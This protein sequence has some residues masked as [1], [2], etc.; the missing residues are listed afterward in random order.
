[1]FEAHVL[2]LLRRYLGEYVHGLSAEALRISVWK[3]DVVLKDLKLKAEAL[4][5]LRLPVMVKAGFVGTITLKVPWKSLGKEPVIV[6]IDRVF[7]LAHPAP[8]GRTLEKEDHEKLFEAKLRQ[9]E[10]AESA[11][12]EAISRSKIGS[13]TSGSSWLTSLIATIIG[14]LKISVSNIHIRYEDTVNNPGHPF[15]CGVTLSKL[16][17]VTTDEQGNETFDTSGALDKLRKSLQLER[18]AMYHDSDSDPWK[19]SKKW[20]DLIPQEWIEIFEDGIK[21]PVKD[22]TV[23]SVWARDRKYVVSPINGVLKYHRLGD[24]E[25]DD[26]N[27]PFEKASVAINDVTLTITEPQYHDWIRLMEVISRYKMY[28]EV[29][30]LRPMVPVSNNARLWWRFGAQAGLQLKKMCYRFSWDQI[31]SLCHL[32]RR[33][34]QLYVCLLQ[35]SSYDSSEIRDIEKNLDE[36]VILLWRFLAHAKVESVKSKEAAE[37]RMQRKNSWFSFTWRTPDEDAPI[38]SNSEGSDQEEEKFTKEEWEAINKLLSFQPD[39]D[40]TLHPGK[41]VQ[42]LIRYLIEVS[43]SKA[44]TRIISSDQKEIVCGSF[45]NLQVSTKFKHSTTSCDLTLKF[46][47]LSSPEGSLA[48]SVCSEQKVNALAAHLVHSPA[49]ENVDWKL[50]ATI[51]PCHVTIFVESYYRFLEFVKRSNAVS[52]TV[53]LETATALQHKFEKVTRKAQE[54]IQMVL[55]EHSRFAL[56]IDLDAPKVRIPIREPTSSKCDCHLLLDFGHFTLHTKDSDQSD[57]SNSL[58]SRFYISG[59]DIAALFTNCGS[60][61]EACALTSQP[62]LSPSI[63][64]IGN[65]YALVDPCGMAVVVDKIKVMHPMHPSMRV[66]VQVPGLSIHFSPSRLHRIMELLNILHLALSNAEQDAGEVVESQSTPWNPADIATT[67]RVLVWKGIGYSIA[68]WQPCFL[69]LS[70]LNLYV[71]ESESSH[72]YQRCSSMSGKQVFEVPVANVGGSPLCIAVCARGMDYQKALESFS[73]LIVELGDEEEKATWLR[74]LTHATYRAS[75][76]P[77]VNVLGESNEITPGLTEHQM[78]SAKTAD[79]IISGTLLETRLLLYGEVEDEMHDQN[80]EACILEV[81]ACGGK[82]HVSRWGGDLTAKMKLHSLK[83]KDELQRYFSTGHRYLACS[84]LSD[85]HLNTSESHAKNEH[86]STWEED[87]VFRDA[88]PDFVSLSEA[89]EAAI[90]EMDIPKSTANEV[91]YEVEGSDDSDFVTVIFLTRDPNSPDYDGI[92]TQMCI[93]MS[94]L[95]FF[96]NRPTLVALINLGFD[97][98]AAYSGTGGSRTNKYPDDQPLTNKNQ[99]ETNGHDFVKGLLGHGKGRVIFNLNM[100][101]D[102]VTIF[103][104]QEDGSQLAMLIQERFLLDI[105]VHPSSLAIEGTLGNFRLCD[106]SLGSDHCWGWLCDIRNQGAESLIEFVFKSYSTEDDDYEGYEYSLT[107]RLSAVRIVFLYRFIQEVTAYFMELATPHTEEAI[108]LVDKVR[109]IEWLI[110]KYEIDGA[111]AI[112]LDLALDTPIIVVPKN[113]MSKDFMQLDLGHLRVKNELQWHGCPEKDPSS[114]HIDVLNAEILGINL[115]VG[116]NGCVG[117]PMIREGKDI[118]VYVRRSLRDVFRKVPTFSLEV[119]VGLLHAL[120][121]DKEYNVILDCLSLNLFEQPTLPPSFRGSKSLSKDT[122]KFLA[123]KVNL[124]GQV[125]LS[126]TVNVIVVE[127]N[128]ALLELYNGGQEESPL[129]HLA[130]EGLWV[131]YRMTSL[132]EADLYI[133]IPNLSF[134]DIRPDTKQEMRLMLGS[135]TDALKPPDRDVDLPRSTMFLM[136]CRWRLSSQSFVLRAQQPRI[137]VV[138]DFLLA[139]CEFFVPALGTITG[140]DEKMNPKNDPLNKSGNIIFYSSVY[141]QIDDIVHLSSKRKLVAD[142]VGVEEYIYDGCGKTLCLNDEK[143]TKDSHRPGFQ[144]IIIIG[145]GKRLRFVNVKIENGWL[146]RKYTYLSCDSSYSVS[147][148]D[149]VE[150]VMLE[151]SSFS[152]LE[153][154][155]IVEEPPNSSDSSGLVCSEPNPVQSFSF[156]AQVVS[157]EFTFYDSSKSFLE[158][159]LLGEKLLR[160]KM[161][162]SFMY[163]SK[164]KDKWVRG[165]LKDLTIEA[166]SGLVILDPVD[167]SGGYTSIKDKTNISLMST[168]I[169]I[170]LSLGVISLLLNLQTQVVTASELGSADPLSPCTNFDRLWVSS[171]ENGPNNKLTFWRPRAPPNYVILG[172]CVTSRPIPPSQAVV[173]V[174]N[175]YGRVRKPLGFK[176]IGSFPCIQKLGE[177]EGSA[178]VDGV[179]SLWLPIAPSG[180]VAAGCVAYLGI[181]QPPNHIVHCIRA[182]LVTSSVYSECILSASSNSSFVSGFSIWRV[183]NA[184]GSFYAHSSLSSPPKYSSIDV[185]HLLLSSS[186][187][188][189]IPEESKLDPIIEDENQCQQTNDGNPMSS[190]WDILRSI[191]NSTSYYTSTPNFERIWWDRGGDYRRAVSIWRPLCRPGYSI[192]GDCITEGL[193]PPSL[194]IIFK[195][196]NHEISAKPLQFTKVAY[197]GRK[198]SDEAFFWY[199]VAPPGYASLGCLVTRIDEAPR[200]ELVCC[201]LMDLVRQANVLEIPIT[202]SSSSKGSSTWSIWR[203]ENQASTFL[204]R[205]DLKKPSGRLAFAIGDTVKQKTRDNVTSELKIRRVSLTV[206][207]NLCGTITPLFDATITNLKLATHGQLEAMNAVLISSIAASTFNAQLE[208]WEPLVESFDG[209]FKFET[210]SNNLHPPLK[211]GKRLRVAATSILNINLTAA[212]LETFVQ[213][214]TSWKVHREIEEKAMKL[215]EEANSQEGRV[216][217]FSMSALDEDDLQTITIENKLG[218]DVYLRK[219]E[220]NSDTIDLL[221]DGDYASVWVTPPRYSDRLNV[222]NDSRESRRYVSVQ[223]V[224]AKALP[225][226]DDGNG[227]NYFCAVRLVIENQDENQQKLFPQSAR[228]KCVKP[229]IYKVNDSNQGIAKW[230]EIFFFEVPRKGTAKLE[231]EVTNLAAKAGKGEVVGAASFSVA[232]HGTSILKKVASSRMMHHASEIQN[233]VSYPLKKRGQVNVDDTVLCGHLSVAASYFERKMLANVRDDEVRVNGKDEDVGFWLGLA[234]EGAW[235]SVKSFLP[236]SVIT[237]SLNGDFFAV[238]VFTRNGKKHAVIRGLASVINDSDVKLDISVSH[239]TA[240]SSNSISVVSPGSDVVLPWRSITENSNCCL[241]VRPHLGGSQDLYGWGRL[242]TLGEQPSTVQGSLGRQGTSKQPNKMPVPAVNLNMLEKKDALLSCPDMGGNMFWLSVCID[243]SVLHTEHNSPV[244]DWKMS[245]SSPLKLE[246]RLPCPAQYIVWE[247]QK[248]GNNIERQ[249]GYMSSRETVHLYSVDVRNPIYL[250]LIVQGGWV[251]EKDPILVL[252]LTSNNHVSS[253]SMVNQQRK[254]RLRVSIERDMGGTAAAPKIIRFFVPYWICNESSLDLVY[255]V[256]EIEQLENVE[257]DNLLLSKAVKSSKSFKNSSATMVGRQVDSRKNIQILEEIEETSSAPCMLSPQDYIGRGG[258]MLFSS[259]NDAYLSPRVGVTVAIRNSENFS[260]GISLLELEKKQR[261]DLKAFGYDGSY[262]LLSALLHMTS[263][264]TKVVHFQ[265]HTLFIN[266][267]GCRLCLR[268]CGTESQECIEPTDPPK[269]FGWQSSKVQL[270]QLR[271]DGCEWSAPFSVG[272]EGMMSICLRSEANCVISFIRVEVRSGTKSSRYEV[273]FRPNSYSTPYRIENRSLFLAVCFRQ[274]GGTSDSLRRLPPNAAVSFSWEDLGRERMLELLID[275]MDPMS[276]Q[277]YNIDEPSNH[278]Q[279]LENGTDSRALCV[280]VIKEEKMHVVKIRDWSAKRISRGI[281]HSSLSQVTATNTSAQQAV[282]STECEFHVIV[283]VGELGLSIVDHT[284]EEILYFS[285]QNLLLSYSTGLGSGV[286]RIKIRMLGIQVDNQLPLTPTPVLF[287]PNRVGEETDYILK[288]S[289]TRQSN[290]LLDL[291]VYPYIGLQ[292]PVN[293]AFLINIHEPIIWRIHGM[294]QHVDISR[295]FDNQSTSVSIDPIVQIGVLNISEIRFKVSL[296]MS[297][298]QRPVGVLGF[299]S[300]LMTALGNTENMPVRINQRFQENVCMRYSVLMGNAISNIKKDVL[301]QPLQLLS[302][303]DI[304]GNASSALGHMSKGVAA[305]SMDKKFIQSRQ[306]KDNKGVEDFGDVIREGGGA[307]AKGLFRGVTGILTKPLEGAKASG[308]EGFVQGV[309]KGLIG[310]AAQPVSGVLDL[311]S[312]TTEGANAMR[313]KIAAAI[314]SEDQLLRRRLPR[315]IGGDNLLR[316]YDEHKAQGQ[317]IL[318]LAECGSFFGQVDL[319]KV[320]GKFAL[321]DAYEDHFLLPKGRFLLVTHR[322]VVLLQV[323][324]VESYDEDICLSWSVLIFIPSHLE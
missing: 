213:A 166:G 72:G 1:M 11:T 75:A 281:L 69:V 202:R 211:L 273:I 30:H 223:I 38:G 123:D 188:Y 112:K 209:I 152:N 290:G 217:N 144:P 31:Q 201:P 235:E 78:L 110:E 138:P 4:N 289:M 57:E 257:A 303:V 182:D 114:V 134:L 192:L 220:Q 207:D 230:H 221:H 243:A 189:S 316:P 37:Q 260:P 176:L 83:I 253:F 161:D 47:G 186:R 171:N 180:Y 183:D 195:T 90:L 13:P 61:R 5:A 80:E 66:S 35:Q 286:S 50:S 191:S 250:I 269:Q 216:K 42:N 165:H 284:P 210:Y 163:S 224:E 228:T 127:V 85:E 74:G 248:D 27:I 296:A 28:V 172:D 280:G 270:L 267:L 150:L 10:A 292:G 26:P 149:G 206:L 197:I 190:G 63:E 55:E 39:K 317:V 137:L 262:F 275:G 263:D 194:G 54:Q 323:R 277:K 320:R 309:G 212:N 299:W 315:A 266:R 293:S 244:Y 132:S 141:K 21:E 278:Q 24:Q 252:D 96:C 58:Y 196:D 113:S 128:Y 131:S 64:D 44:A 265:P 322:R 301:S 239:L 214:F 254:R 291:C 272:I 234:P 310:A 256:V 298:T 245:I 164:E 271:L 185:N 46:Y 105:K 173:S 100:N 258:I 294:I 222:A 48:E 2:H 104:N 155:D 146:L 103:L 177:D 145:R 302:G 76:P 154:L 204:A 45:E 95:E 120:M 215:N 139:V 306:R 287:R 251:V 318:Q 81:L 160:A 98:N 125:L 151:F 175:A 7:I 91:F 111:T 56:D 130:L 109:G 67:A 264:R 314:A 121:S 25:R 140:R 62:S 59:R 225:I 92:D 285:I 135:C 102:C 308:V 255:R 184:L 218:C 198:G 226:L 249:R 116:I 87:D 178:D 159:G 34:I 242:T 20:E 6:L 19:P 36:K 33:Y 268:Q 94:K 117:K 77:S 232:G 43:I 295:L 60:T 108:K 32:R 181:E 107:G 237:R 129:A 12:L 276:A 142:T 279:L 8:D 208:A 124:N 73:T 136:D 240:N 231:V 82:V 147:P 169:Y 297:P 158:D 89:T 229:S 261:V 118:H 29:S 283:E 122:I 174:N 99:I 79:L 68:A 167:I 200:L 65:A 93:R 282:S 274:V 40:V 143:E 126:R 246:N 14:N 227:H 86:G 311:L 3:G 88:L 9:I 300:S 203:V 324:S 157:P 49:G 241:Q 18:L 52:P 53:A 119:Q 307:L 153:G 238:E 70:G 187:S 162:F 84:V 51:S 199:P 22:R 115:A 288:F 106:L 304:L 193:E 41:E 97:L 71:L 133:T 15:A 170:H 219:A 148:E 319:F 233:V 17:A 247:R 321:S 205:P 313:M 236:P 168:D 179:C 156:E 259:K 312:K 101:V 16:A 305:L 23:P